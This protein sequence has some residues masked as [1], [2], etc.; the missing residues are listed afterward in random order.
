MKSE[1]EIR[2][3]LEHTAKV[4][5]FKA[6]QLRGGYAFPLETAD[7]LEQSADL[8]DSLIETNETET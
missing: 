5:R 6:E 3:W 8:L 7:S 2:E 4:L 1:A